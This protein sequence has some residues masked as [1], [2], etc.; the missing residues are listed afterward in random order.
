[1]VRYKGRPTVRT[2]EKTYPFIVELQVP[3]GGFRGKSSEMA[4]WYVERR[5]QH[6]A[7]AGRYSEGL[8]F[9]RE[10]FLQAEDAEAFSMKFGGQLTGPGHP[11]RQPPRGGR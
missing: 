5:L 7:G 9:T 2:V 11:S 1:M 10:C 8:W 3:E 4:A 6:M